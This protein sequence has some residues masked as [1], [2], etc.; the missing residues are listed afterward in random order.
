MDMDK[1]TRHQHYVWRKYLEAWETDGRIWC[2]FNRDGSCKNVNPRYLAVE[3]DFYKIPRM[4][5]SDFKFI[6]DLVVKTTKGKVA[7]KANEDTLKFFKRI[8]SVI[9]FVDDDSDVPPEILA[10]INNFLTTIEEK[11]HAQIEKSALHILEQLVAGNADSFTSDDDAVAFSMFLGRQYFRTKATQQN[12]RA[13]FAGGPLESR[14]DRCWP[15]LRQMWSTNVGA[16]IFSLRHEMRWQL[17]ETPQSVPFIT[18]DQPVIN[19][20][21]AFTPAKTEIVECEFYYPVSPHRAVFISGHTT[22]RNLDAAILSDFMVNIFN[23]RMEQCARNQLYANQRASLA[24]V[25]V[26]FGVEV[27]YDA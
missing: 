2:L 4:L 25:K 18:G 19:T 15:V 6:E 12:I 27:K 10:H 26:P 13:Q 5:T 24:N 21:G 9:Q 22:Q 23:L 3:I 14:F 17:L 7:R 1:I 11:E 16:S 20:Y 8:F